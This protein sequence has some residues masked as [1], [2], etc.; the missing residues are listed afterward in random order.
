MWS[1]QGWLSQI[2]HHKIS[3]SVKFLK[4]AVTPVCSTVNE[5]RLTI[6]NESVKKVLTFT[7]EQAKERESADLLNSLI[8]TTGQELLEIVMSTVP[9]ILFNK[10]FIFSQMREN[11][12]FIL[13][14]A[15]PTKFPLSCMWTVQICYENNQL[16]SVPT[17]S[18]RFMYAPFKRR[19]QIHEIHFTG[20]WAKGMWN[21]VPRLLT[22][23]R[24]QVCYK[25][26]GDMQQPW[27][28]SKSCHNNH[29]Y[30]M[31]A[32]IIL[33]LASLLWQRA[34]CSSNMQPESVEASV[35]YRMLQ[36]VHSAGPLH[37]RTGQ[38]IPAQGRCK[39]LHAASGWQP[40]VSA[41]QRKHWRDQRFTLVRL[42]PVSGPSLN[43]S[44][45]CFPLTGA[46]L[47]LYLD[48]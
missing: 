4:P 10:L 43:W 12:F 16:G 46:L 30:Y 42:K 26:R 36:Y 13:P 48:C 18:F 8:I 32:V 21:N 29:S 47:I 25:E 45:R 14:A 6:I 35:R 20:H 40:E 3:D 11:T 17:F 9:W 1:K 24:M 5:I 23:D 2:T 7:A 22:Y 15:V 27:N 41:L 44:K 34:S 39:D 38:L 28:G 19:R 33:V 31:N 37:P